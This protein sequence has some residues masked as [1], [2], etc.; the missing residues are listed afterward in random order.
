MNEVDVTVI[1]ILTEPQKYGKKYYIKVRT[2]C[3]GHES[4]EALLFNS[5]EEAEQIEIG[6]KFEG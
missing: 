5:K 3:E 6:Y 2:D 4:T 1:A